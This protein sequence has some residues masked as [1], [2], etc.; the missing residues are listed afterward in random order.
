MELPKL[1]ELPNVCREVAENSLD[2]LPGGKV[3]NP[4]NQAVHRGLHW[5][6]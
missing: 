2:L 3:I 4:L 5:V 1:P 6:D